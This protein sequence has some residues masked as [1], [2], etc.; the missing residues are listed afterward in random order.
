MA[1]GWACTLLDSAMG[2]AV[3]TTLDRETGYTHRIV[4]GDQ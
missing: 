4:A 2:S 1:S 3:M